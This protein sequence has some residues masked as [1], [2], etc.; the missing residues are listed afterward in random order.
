MAAVNGAGVGSG[1]T[2]LAYADIVIA[3]T[4]ARFKAPFVAMGLAP[5]QAAAAP[6]P[7][8]SAG[9]QPLT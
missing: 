9:R 4:T 8:S 5:R 2:M 6:C 1:F 7:S 3:S